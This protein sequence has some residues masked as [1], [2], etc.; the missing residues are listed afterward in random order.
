MIYLMFPLMVYALIGQVR[1]D[2]YSTF[3]SEYE[4][5]NETGLDVDH[6]LL[7]M[8]RICRDYILHP[9]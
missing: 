5:G 1:V 9:I 4:G 2:S 3:G 6:T 8:Q 7:N